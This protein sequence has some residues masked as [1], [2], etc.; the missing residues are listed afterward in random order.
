MTI[1]HTNGTLA[2]GLEIYWMS[3][4]GGKLIVY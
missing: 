4:T 2:Q 1:K 3:G